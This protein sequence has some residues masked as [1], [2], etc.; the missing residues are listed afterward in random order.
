MGWKKCVEINVERKFNGIAVFLVES[1]IIKLKQL[2]L[3]CNG[4]QHQRIYCR[5]GYKFKNLEAMR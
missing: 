5:A 2:Y 4:I 1:K 3:T